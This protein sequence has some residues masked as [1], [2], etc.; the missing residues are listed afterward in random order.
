MTHPQAG[1]LI[2]FVAEITPAIEEMAKGTTS[3]TAVGGNEHQ[4]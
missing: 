3:A 1:E 2:P 4:D